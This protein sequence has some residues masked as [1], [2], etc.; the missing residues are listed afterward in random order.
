[1]KEILDFLAGLFEEGLSYRYISLVRSAISAYHTP[2]EGIN[3][4]RH[5]LICRLMTGMGIQTPPQPRYCVIWDVEKVL[6][7]LRRLPEDKDLPLDLLTHKTAMLLALAA[8]SR[9]SELWLLDINLMADTENMIL[10]YFQKAPKNFKKLGAVPKPLEIHAS[11]MHLCPV[12]TSLEYRSRT[13]SLRGDVTQFFVRTIRPHVGVTRSTI[14]RWLKE[15]LKKTG[16]DTTAFAGHSTRAASTS[17]AHARG[18]SVDDILKRGGWS[19]FSTWQKFY[20]KN[21]ETPSL[22]FQEKLFNQ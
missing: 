6:D 19:N 2:I 8:V 18:A 15:V 20:N 21:I 5:H 22:R 16:V 17:K 1:M 14:G 11:H 9:G 13:A 7:Y 12:K 10:F 3:V 4:G